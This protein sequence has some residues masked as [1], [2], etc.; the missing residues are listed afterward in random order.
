[1][2]WV[3]DDEEHDERDW[4][5]EDGWWKLHRSWKQSIQIHFRGSYASSSR[6]DSWN[7][8]RDGFANTEQSLRKKKLF[9]FWSDW[10]DQTMSSLLR[11]ET[12]GA[13]S[14]RL[15]QTGVGKREADG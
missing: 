3:E 12:G 5:E 14:M 10:V 2:G 1:M 11:P 8:T 13:E 9:E 15:T 6:K 7:S 4:C